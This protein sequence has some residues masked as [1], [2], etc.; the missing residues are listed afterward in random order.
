MDKP[1]AYRLKVNQ[2]MKLGKN[3]INQIMKLVMNIIT[4]LLE[5]FG[6]FFND[7]SRIL[8]GKEERESQ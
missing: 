1:G 2:T 5:G 7:E 6:L 8:K 4:L 3:I